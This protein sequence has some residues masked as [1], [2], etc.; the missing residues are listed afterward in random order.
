MRFKGAKAQSWKEQA[1]ARRLKF[2]VTKSLQSKN[3]RTIK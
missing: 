1:E 2:E 3:L